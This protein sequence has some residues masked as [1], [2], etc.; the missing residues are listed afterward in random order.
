MECRVPEYGDERLDDFRRKVETVNDDDFEHV[1]YVVYKTCEHADHGCPNEEERRVNLNLANQSSGSLVF[2]DDVEVRF[3]ASERED[4][5]DKKTACTDKSEFFDGD[6]LGIFD[7]VH[8]LL[9]R[10]VQIEHVNHDGEVVRNEVTEPD[11]E[12][13]GSEHDEEW[14]DCHERRV[15]QRCGTG[16]SVIVQE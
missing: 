9:G 15:G 8:D 14:D 5:C 2:P 13:D 10:P 4:K 3:E 1:L 7:D 16:H 6:V 11:G 12:R